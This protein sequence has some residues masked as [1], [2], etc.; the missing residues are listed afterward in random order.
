MLRG[1]LRAGAAGIDPQAATAQEALVG[2]YAETVL[3]AAPNQ[4]AAITLGAEMLYDS[5]LSEL[6][7]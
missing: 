1:V 3:A 2:F 7:I 6:A 5:R 4:L